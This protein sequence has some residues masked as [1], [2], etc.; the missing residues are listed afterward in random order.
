[1]QEPQ[2]TK[3]WIAKEAGALFMRYGIRSVS[4]DD[5]ARQV[6]MSKKTLYQH[7]NDKDALVVAVVQAKF[8]EDRHDFD[9]VGQEAENTIE[10][11]IL[12]SKMF[13]KR[14]KDLNPSLLYDLKKYYP[15]A[16]K[17]FEEHREACYEAMLKNMLARGKQEGYFRKEIN[18]NIL[19]RM[20]IHQVEM[21]FDP[22]IFPPQDFDTWE[23]QRSLLDL[24]FNGICTT[25]GLTKMAEYTTNANT[26]II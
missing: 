13:R 14:V 10:E 6:S 9:S 25:K 5:I 19:V 22:D 15:K 23:V 24:F 2:D 1:M 16:W 21:G 7:Y 20:R 11:C 12:F 3:A 4:M 26:Q 18:E 8:E 17:M